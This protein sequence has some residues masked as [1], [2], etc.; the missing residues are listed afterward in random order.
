MTHDRWVR[1]CIPTGRTEQRGSKKFNV[2]LESVWND[3]TLR[4]G[5]LNVKAR[6]EENAHSITSY[7]TNHTRANVFPAASWF[8][9]VVCPAFVRFGAVTLCWGTARRNYARVFWDSVGVFAAL[10][11][12][13]KL[14][15]AAIGFALAAL[16]SVSKRSGSLL[17][18]QL[19]KLLA[20]VFTQHKMTDKISPGTHR[21]FFHSAATTQCVFLE[22]FEMVK[23]KMKMVVAI[24]KKKF[25]DF[26]KT[27]SIHI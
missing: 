10:C 25:F 5:L 24:K 4:Q 14:K 13:L 11:G 2:A 20:L 16:V 8:M 22:E 23:K 1:C 26:K 17:E 3:V 12:L 9:L 18:I 7:R 21:A 15:R 19:W 6:A 27:I